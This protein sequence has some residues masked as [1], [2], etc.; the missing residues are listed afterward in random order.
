[1]N[2]IDMPID[3]DVWGAMLE[4]C[5]RYTQKLTDTAKLKDCCVDDME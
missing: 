5:Q 2:Q 1:M 4:C 3:Y